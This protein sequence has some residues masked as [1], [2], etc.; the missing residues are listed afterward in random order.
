MNGL[1][2]SVSEALPL[3]SVNVWRDPRMRQSEI[4]PSREVLG[5]LSLSKFKGAITSALIFAASS[6]TPAQC[7]QWGSRSRQVPT[8]NRKEDA[9]W[10]ALMAR[11]D[12]R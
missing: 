7:R 9:G 8:R 10:A 11:R 2:L 5:F 4:L 3:R 6:S 12:N 1:T